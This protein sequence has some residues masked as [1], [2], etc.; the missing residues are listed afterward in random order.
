MDGTLPSS[1]SAA[2]PVNPADVAAATKAQA[3]AAK[4]AE[5]ARAD[6]LAF[7]K[8]AEDEFL[9]ATTDRDAAAVR[10]QATLDSAAAAR[11]AAGGPLPP[12]LPPP[13]PHGGDKDE[14][15]PLQHDLHDAMLLHKAAA[16]LNLHAQAVLIQNIRSLIPTTLD[17]NSGNYAR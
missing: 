10:I 3:D 1:P 12:P 2:Q 14:Y 15:A 13:P 7:I 6:V 11:R 16:V 5:Q 4:A 9:K 8:A 17:I